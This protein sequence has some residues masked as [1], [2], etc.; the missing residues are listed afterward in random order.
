[1]VMQSLYEAKES[2]LT[3][4]AENT[5]AASMITSL[6]QQLVEA[7]TSRTRTEQLHS[8]I[9]NRRR[10]EMRLIRDEYSTELQDRDRELLN[11]RSELV[12][13]QGQ[14]EDARSQILNDREHITKLRDL[15]SLCAGAGATRAAHAYYEC[16]ALRRA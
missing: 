11:C 8:E 3:E 12:A 9:E 1:M 6:R 7:N 13:L 14:L 10:Q 16:E 5:A 4:Q 15:V 2:V